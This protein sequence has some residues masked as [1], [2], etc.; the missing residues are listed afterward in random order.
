MGKLEAMPSPPNGDQARGERDVDM[1]GV[2]MK[3]SMH[4]FLQCFDL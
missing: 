3:F 2:R 1:G 4:T